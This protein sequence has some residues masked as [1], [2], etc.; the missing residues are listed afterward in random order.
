VIGGSNV[1]VLA[2]PRVAA[3]PATSNPGEVTVTA[4]GVGRNIAENLAR[5]GTTVSLVS[6]V[7]SDV[8]GDLV[9]EAT[10]DAG[11]DVE[12]VR[13]GLT[14]TGTY[15]ALLDAEGE[16]VAAVSDMAATASLGTA[17][18]HLAGDAIAAA[19]LVVLDGNLST[20]VLAT[21]WEA[22]VTAGVGVVLDPVS[23][24]KAAAIGHLL[25]V[26]RPLALLSA[27]ST[28]LEALARDGASLLDRGVAVLW[29]RAGAAGSLLRTREASVELASL[30]AAVEDVTGAGDAMLAAYC[31]AVLTGS[32]PAEAARYGHAAA[33]LTVGSRHTVRP[34]LTDANVRSLL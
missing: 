8:H 25:G 33:A 11:V 1:D 13:R 22:A 19:D 24:P 29:E 15:V 30:P 32:T 5:L 23:V 26:E 6:V 9:L 20:E 17:D 7:G 2:R 12:L 28:E 21:A 14:P 27:G 3:L 16:L 34:D 31:H 18:V 10:R 4:G